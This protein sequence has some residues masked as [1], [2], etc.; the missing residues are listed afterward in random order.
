[1]ENGSFFVD[2]K[3]LHVVKLVG[4]VEQMDDHTTNT[5]YRINDG[6]GSVDCKFWTAKDKAAKAS[7]SHIV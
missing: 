4:Y 3:E 2:D 1:M 7:H 5:E 6:T